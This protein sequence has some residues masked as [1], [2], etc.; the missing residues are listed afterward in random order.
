MAYLVRINGIELPV[1]SSYT[2][3]TIDI[4]DSGRNADGVI[5]S[6]IVRSNV[7]SIDLKWNYLTVEEWSNILAFFKNNFTNTVT[8]FDMVEGG[9]MSKEMYIGDRDADMSQFKNG[10]PTAWQNCSLSLVEV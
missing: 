8:Y 3:K 4:V 10:I 1:P 9:Y 2:S 7:S 6:Q 5:V